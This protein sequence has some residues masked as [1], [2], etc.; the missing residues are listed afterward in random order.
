MFKKSYVLQV[1]Q[2]VRQHGLGKIEFYL[3]FS[4]SLF[5]C[6]K[7]D[8]IQQLPSWYN[9]VWEALQIRRHHGLM[10]QE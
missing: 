4:L 9:F 7:Q 8:I 3:L 6:A 2:Q 10:D 5:V 1:Q